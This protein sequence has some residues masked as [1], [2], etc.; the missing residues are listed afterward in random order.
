M[1]VKRSIKNLA[2][3]LATTA[4]MAMSGIAAAA[5]S[6]YNVTQSFGANGT[7]TATFTGEEIIFDQVL[8]GNE[9]TSLS[10]SFSGPTYTG[11]FHNVD[12][13]N[14]AWVIGDTNLL[15]VGTSITVATLPTSSSPT[16]FLWNAG[17]AIFQPGDA[18]MGRVII[19]SNNTPTEF[20]TLETA[21]VT[22]AAAVPEPETYALMLAG[23]GVL[24]ALGRR[25]K[26]AQ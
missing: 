10:L 2:T 3:L 15:D 13:T 14:M 17:G 24:G 20:R 12:T 23:L 1:K 6:T 11:S 19:S 26:R 7:L 5:P 22:N 21:T 4:L 18:M 25:Q 8:A 9:I 16:T